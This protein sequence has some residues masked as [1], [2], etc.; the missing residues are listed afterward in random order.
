M[1]TVTSK[2]P[3][4]GSCTI[5]GET[6][7]KLC[8]CLSLW[9]E[10]P[11]SYR[12]SSKYAPKEKMGLKNQLDWWYES[13]CY[14]MMRYI[15]QSQTDS[16]TIE[17]YLN[18]HVNRHLTGYPKEFENSF[19]LPILPEWV[20]IEDKPLPM[21]A[22]LVDFFKDL[23][24]EIESHNG[25]EKPVRVVHY[26]QSVI[27]SVRSIDLALA[28]STKMA[29]DRFRNWEFYDRNYDAPKKIYLPEHPSFGP[30]IVDQLEEL[31]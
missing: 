16:P 13:F 2:Y 10:N 18:T 15:V 23:L 7:T 8:L 9:A 5:C 3:P 1:E 28:A 27:S 22:Y 20:E 30:L 25:I 26:V 4:V 14:P 24:D 19:Y 6:D 29:G 12:V 31:M 17:I 11:E 21:L